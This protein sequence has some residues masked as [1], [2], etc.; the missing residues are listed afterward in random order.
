VPEPR[1]PLV[2]INGPNYNVFRAIANHQRI[3]ETFVPFLIAAY[4]ANSLTPMQ[5]EVAWLGAS[6]ANTC[7]Y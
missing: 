5:R 7:H 6:A 3:Y 2:D 4:A 1:L